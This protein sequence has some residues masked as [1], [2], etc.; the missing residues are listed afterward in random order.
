M[1]LAPYLKL[2]VEK[3][4]SDLYFSSGA[5]V[6]IKVEGVTSHLGETPLT[7]GTVKGLAYSIMNDE[8]VRSFEHQLEMDLAFAVAELGRF[9]INVFRQRGEVAMVVRY[10][11]HEIPPIEALNLPLILKDLVMEPRGLILVVGT[12]GSGK[13]TTLA[14]M[15]DYRNEHKTGHILTIEDPIEY[16]HRHKRS[17]VNQREVGVDTRSYSDALRRAMREAPD[18]IL[19]GE[20]R[21]RETMEQ[22]IAY[23]ETGHLCLST[24]HATNAS[25]TLQRIV[26][27]FPESAHKKLYMDL[28]FQ[29]TAIVSQ[30]LLMGRDEKRVPAVE[31]LLQ[32]PYIRELI[33]NGQIDQVKEVMEKATELGMHTFDQ[34]LFD[35][36]S[37]G[38]ISEDEALRYADSRHNLSVRIRLSKGGR[39][40]GEYHHE[41]EPG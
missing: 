21:D 9:R 12:T 26:N 32:S 37:G 2:M 17:I 22:A 39:L 41:G 11:R 31:I 6:S 8:Q 15:I 28:A 4:A 5:P 34:A 40:P 13:S 20:I 18:V 30:R 33:Q 7:P 3:D 27:F 1:D 38:R 36:Y 19:I 25:Q 24:L 29:L 10:I 35:L 23:A 16:S 14:S